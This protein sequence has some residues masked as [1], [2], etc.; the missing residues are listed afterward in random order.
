MKPKPEQT[1]KRYELKFIKQLYKKNT[2]LYRF[3]FDEN[4]L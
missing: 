4:V 1:I 3:T 2:I